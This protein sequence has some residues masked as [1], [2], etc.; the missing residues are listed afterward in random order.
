MYCS[1]VLCTLWSMAPIVKSTDCLSKL[2]KGFLAFYLYAD[3][4]A[5]DYMNQENNNKELQHMECMDF[6]SCPC[7][8]TQGGEQTKMLKVVFIAKA[9][10]IEN[11][12]SWW[13]KVAEVFSH[14]LRRKIE[15][16]VLLPVLK[17]FMLFLVWQKHKIHGFWL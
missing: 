5:S 15:G 14:C 6:F 7:H 9:Q 13:Q 1:D 8:K 12:Y 16:F 3:T 4:C 10:G 17:M 11:Y 2:N